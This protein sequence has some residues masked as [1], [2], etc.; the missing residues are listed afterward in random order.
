MNPAHLNPRFFQHFDPK[1]WEKEVCADLAPAVRL[2]LA[3]PGNGIAAMGLENIKMPDL[4][5][6][7]RR[8]PSAGTFA[9]LEALC[10]GNPRL[11]VEAGWAACLE[12][13]STV[14]WDWPRPTAEPPSTNE[15]L[16]NRLFG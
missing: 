3:E 11:R 6:L 8:P 16:F 5:V 14:E 10:A 1:D 12:H 4:A 2:L 15:S 7:L 9:E 13:Y